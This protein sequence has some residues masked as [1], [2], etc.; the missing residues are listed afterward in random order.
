MLIK[1]FRFIPGVFL[2]IR[3]DFCLRKLNCKNH[4]LF[5][6]SFNQYY[7]NGQKIH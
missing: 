7:L 5:S 6:V 2:K 4:C 3:V 1:Y